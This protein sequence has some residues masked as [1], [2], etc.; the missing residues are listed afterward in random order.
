MASQMKPA[1]YNVTTV[2]VTTARNGQLLPYVFRAT[3]RQL[4][5]PGF[6]RVYDVDDEPVGEDTAHNEQL[7]PLAR[8]DGLDCHKLLPE[9]HF[10][11]PPPYFTDATLIQ[12]LERLGIGRPSTFASIVDTLYQRDYAGKAPAGRGLSATQ[13]GRVVCDF[14]VG[15]F[16]SVFEVG[17]TARLEDQLDDIANGEA[18]WTAVMGGLWGPLSSLITQTQGALAGQPKIRVPAEA[19][20]PGGRDGE[21]EEPSMPSRR[22]GKSK[23]K[24]GAWRGRG[25]GGKRAPRGKRGAAAGSDG[26]AAATTSAPHTAAAP[27]G[28]DCPKCGKPLVRRTSKFGPFVGCSGYPKCRYIL[29]QEQPPEL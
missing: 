6:L 19:A 4:L 17:F 8:G 29:K 26:E 25:K 21:A 13:L 27:T 20:G 23:G 11:K 24:G 5:D 3:G 14:L 15:H 18:Q 9:Q 16:P 2:T 22:Y 12:E 7:P 28:Q 1:V 10:T